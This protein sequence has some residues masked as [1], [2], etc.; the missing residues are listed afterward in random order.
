M[1]DVAEE[2]LPGSCMT[3]KY[4][5]LALQSRKNTLSFS[6]SMWLRDLFSDQVFITHILSPSCV[7]RV[8]WQM[9]SGR[10]RRGKGSVHITSVLREILSAAAE[11]L[12]DLDQEP[13]H[14][15][16]LAS[17]FLFCCSWLYFQLQVIKRDRRLVQNHRMTYCVWMVEKLGNDWFSWGNAV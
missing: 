12:F 13:T 2:L 10:Q 6:F 5:V 15:P 16:L 17:E 1:P 11:V 4:R 3:L 7:C 8:L 14:V 9:V